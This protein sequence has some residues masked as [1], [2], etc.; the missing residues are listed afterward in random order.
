MD[1]R[2]QLNFDTVFN[3][4][5]VTLT[6]LPIPGNLSTCLSQCSSSPTITKQFDD[7]FFKNRVQGPD[8]KIQV[9]LNWKRQ[10]NHASEER[11][12]IRRCL[13][14]LHSFVLLVFFVNMVNLSANVDPCNPSIWMFTFC[15]SICWIWTFSR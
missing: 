1:V 3:T 7:F 14:A 12:E 8:L 13:K 15:H 9:I 10:T 11:N 4:Y 6:P 2:W 5:Y